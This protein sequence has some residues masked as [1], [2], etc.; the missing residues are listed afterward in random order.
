MRVVKAERWHMVT[1][2]EGPTAAG[3][4]TASRRCSVCG[5]RRLVAHEDDV[6]DAATLRRYRTVRCEG[7]G[8]DLLE[9]LAAPAPAKLA[10][11]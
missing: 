11:C 2:D 7:C 3:A 10:A 6:V 5:S 4:D 8:Y 9:P 1:T